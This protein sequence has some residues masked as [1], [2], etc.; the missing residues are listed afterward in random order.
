MATHHW[1]IIC[2]IKDHVQVGITAG[3]GRVDRVKEMRMV[4]MMVIVGVKTGGSRVGG[5][6]LCVKADDNRIQGTRCFYPG[7]GPL[8]GGKTLLLLD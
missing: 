5:P 4:M 3:C 7:L 6:E 8:D 1:I 2:S